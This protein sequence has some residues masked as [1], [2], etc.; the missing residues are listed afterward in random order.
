MVESASDHV[1]E[2]I[3]N[4][5][6]RTS[7]EYCRPGYESTLPLSCGSLISLVV[8]VFN[9]HPFNHPPLAASL[10][11]LVL[12]SSS[13]SLSCCCRLS[14]VVSRHRCL[15][16]IIIVVSLSL[17]SSSSLVV[18][19]FS[20]L[21]SLIVIIFSHCCHHVSCSSHFGLYSWLQKGTFGWGCWI[22]SGWQWST[23]N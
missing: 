14:L 4:D 8:V 2:P 21:S 9:P 17:S 22:R 23:C 13:S 12:L 5:C 19:V 7:G 3:A 20:S 6:L 1:D 10:S 16:L 11:S 18:V 15:S